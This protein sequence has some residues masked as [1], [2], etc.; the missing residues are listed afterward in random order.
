MDANDI[1]SL[2]ESKAKEL[3][4]VKEVFENHLGRE[5]SFE[6]A[7]GLNEILRQNCLKVVSRD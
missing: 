5:L 2:A 3:A 1:W 7:L 4:L 6:D